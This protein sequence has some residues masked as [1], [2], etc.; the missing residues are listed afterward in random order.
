MNEKQ[1]RKKLGA[2]ARELR[3]KSKM[4][5]QEVAEKLDIYQNDISAFETRGEKI[6]SLEKINELFSLFGYE[7]NISEK[8]T[9]LISV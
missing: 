9:T 8:K 4:T 7:L 2:K 6:G 3:K 1:L 5:Q